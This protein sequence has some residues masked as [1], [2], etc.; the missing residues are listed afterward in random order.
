[1]SCPS[2]QAKTAQLQQGLNILDDR[3]RA[4]VQL[5]QQDLLQQ[6]E[7]LREAQKF[8]QASRETSPTRHHMC[9]PQTIP[10]IYRFPAFQLLWSFHRC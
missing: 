6:A 3:I 2:L 9:L 10:D 5:R 8:M 1:M 7:C 4:E